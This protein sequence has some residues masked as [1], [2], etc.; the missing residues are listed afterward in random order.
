MLPD[1]VQ[2]RTARSPT[3]GEYVFVV[4][5]RDAP[6]YSEVGATGTAG[7]ARC[8]CSLACKNVIPQHSLR[9]SQIG[10][11]TIQRETVISIKDQHGIALIDCHRKVKR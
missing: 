3:S 5:P 10:K 2:N 8:G 7:A 9:L 6:S 1:I 4:L 11:T